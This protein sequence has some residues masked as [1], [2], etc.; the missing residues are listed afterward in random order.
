MSASVLSTDDEPA[1]G[2]SSHQV[3]NKSDDQSAN[4]T[5]VA[6]VPTR[7]ERL[8]ECGFVIA[9]FVIASCGL[10]AAVTQD[11][12]GIELSAPPAAPAVSPAPSVPLY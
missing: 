8:F 3:S 7:S 5:E 1:R 10:I 9:A 12:H 6:Y 2:V 4:A 11:Y